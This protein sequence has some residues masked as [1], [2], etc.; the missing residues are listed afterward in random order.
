MIREESKHCFKVLGSYALM[1]FYE[2]QP[3]ADIVNL[4]EI[5]YSTARSTS[6]ETAGHYVDETR[7]MALEFVDADWQLTRA[8][9]VLKANGNIAYGDCF[10]AA[11]AKSHQA[12]LV[13]GDKEF[14]VLEDEITI[15]WL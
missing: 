13:I 1:A 11:L 14:K 5:W 4:R 12:E 7:G 2:D 10:A 3:G 15:S 8:A 6:P 9:A